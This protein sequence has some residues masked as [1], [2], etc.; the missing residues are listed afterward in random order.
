MPVHV[1]VR[2][3]SSRILSRDC[4]F[5][6]RKCLWCPVCQSSRPLSLTH[7]LFLSLS[8][9]FSFS[10]SFSGCEDPVLLDFPYLSPQCCMECKEVWSPRQSNFIDNRPIRQTCALLQQLLNH[11]HTR[12]A[13]ERE[14]ERKRERKTVYS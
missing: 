5:L 2:I 14:R 7:F 9:S 13:R 11:R 6:K 4:Y 10:F 3:T 1:L 8:L 12:R